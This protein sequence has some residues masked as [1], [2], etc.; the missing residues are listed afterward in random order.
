MSSASA[1]RA[2]FPADAIF[3]RASAGVCCSE[4]DRAR[5]GGLEPLRL[6]PAGGWRM[7]A[8]FVTIRSPVLESLDGLKRRPSRRG[9]AG[10]GGEKNR[11]AVGDDGSRVSGAAA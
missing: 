11:C 3:N 5:A 7:M 1:A 6:L 10:P 8:G 9:R 4:C 2:K